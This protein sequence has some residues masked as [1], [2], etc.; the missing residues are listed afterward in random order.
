[1]LT[2]REIKG[3]KPESKEYKRYDGDGLFLF[4]TP[5]GTKTW[6]YRYEWHGKERFPKLGRYPEMSLLDARRARDEY[7]RMI[8]DGKNPDALKSADGIGLS[9]LKVSREWAAKK[10]WTDG[11][12]GRN[13]RILEEDLAAHLLMEFDQIRPTDIRACI[14]R[15]EDRGALE[16][17]S[18]AVNMASEIFCYGIGRGYC[19]ND[20]AAPLKVGK[21]QREVNP[22]SAL[23]EHKDIVRLLR[24]IEVYDGYIM[25]S[26]LKFQAYTFMRPSEGRLLE[27]S[28][29]DWDKKIIK[30][31]AERMKKNRLPFI[32]PLADQVIELLR[33]LQQVTG[34]YK[35]VFISKA[36]LPKKQNPISNASA[37]KALRIM[38]FSADEMTV[39]GFRKIAST[40][41][42]GAIND[43]GESMWNSDWIERQLAHVRGSKTSKERAIYNMALYLGGRTPMMQWYADYLDNLRENG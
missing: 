21:I 34:N 26:Y 4:V 20:P 10:S 19:E 13:T 1:M 30:L 11:T 5:K 9:F 41:L 35:Y 24:S 29:I 16:V 3:L 31:S 6:K 15:I 18:R 14:K 8:A 39:H 28:E 27:W 43:R 25:R 7:A 36:G 17:A 23:T 37:L 33:S 22:F 42:N 32:V 2:D 38:G 12:R 40:T